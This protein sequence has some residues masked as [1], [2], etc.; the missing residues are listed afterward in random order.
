M[1]FE[2]EK[3][4]EVATAL[5]QSLSEQMK[6]KGL[7][8]KTMTLK[9]KRSSFS[10][11]TRQTTLPNYT[12]D[13]AVIAQCAKALLRK[14]FPISLR[15][16]GIRV[17]HFKGAAEPLPV[18]PPHLRDAP[19]GRSSERLAWAVQYWRE[20]M[21]MESDDLNIDNLVSGNKSTMQLIKNILE[22]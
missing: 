13:G 9:L 16:M 15:L 12:D 20:K 5:S 22:Q 1:R 14:E 3:L 4:F 21:S 8:G 17:S 19:P 7:M 6:A 11:S 18:C 10:V 2:P